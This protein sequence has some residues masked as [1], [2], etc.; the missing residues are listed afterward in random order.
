[1]NDVMSTLSSK[2]ET[3]NLTELKKYIE[4]TD[5]GI[6]KNSNAVDYS[7]NLKINL[8]KNDDEKITRVNPSTVMNAMGMGD[9]IEAQNNSGMMSSTMITQYDVWQELLDNESLLKAQYNL[10]AGKWPEKYNEVVLIVG[11]DNDIS[12]YTLYA[13]GL[14]DQ[15]ELEDKMKKI[16]KGETVEKGD[17]TSYTYDELLDLSY[18][19]ILNSDYYK[20]EN[21]AWI[22]K[23]EDEEFMKDKIN[24]AEEIKVV[25][26]LKQ[27][28]QS[29]ATGMSGVIGYTKDLEEYVI[30]KSNESD[31]VKEQRDKE[32]INI[33]SGLE[34]PSEEEEKA[35]S[36]DSLSNEQK[37]AMSRL[38]SE[39]IAELMEAYSENKNASYDKNMQKLGAIDLDT[40]SAISIYPKDF[41]AK[42]KIADA[43]ED[44]NNM[45]KDNG[46][47][48][49]TINYTD[50]VG[51]MMKSVNKIVNTV[52]YVLIAFVAISLIVSSIM[53]GI[54]TYISVLERTKE[55]GI[56][57]AMGA[58][59][60][61]I[62]HVFDAETMII[63][64]ISGLIG[65][66]ITVLLTIPINS[67]IYG[68]TG[69]VVKAQVPF[70][71]G[72][73]LVVL[74]VVLTTIAGLIPA[75]IASKKDPVIALRTE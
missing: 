49:N 11:E 57:R 58:S 2:V 41:E 9:I 4:E 63:G 17:S 24:N 8:Y 21:G 32:D 29:V 6:K 28:E 59:K 60:K 34:F 19:L 61:D 35:F 7:Y 71:A 69:V 70:A 45:Q 75:K 67:V 73:F 12:D 56:L 10:L 3:N 66:G 22:D 36:Y 74:S 39:E 33:F 23:S 46:K 51:T 18:R 65:I 31:I 30:N 40:P 48:E 26:I 53:I 5:N 72:V 25:G 55:I 68:L 47:E 16:Q 64:L 62:S 52:S 42:D 50:L 37:M 14:K 1:M 13:L 44:Y 54:I 20:K 15:K 27:D 43:I 38:S